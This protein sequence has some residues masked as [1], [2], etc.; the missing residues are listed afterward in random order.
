M[1][2]WRLWWVAAVFVVGIP[3]G[4][5]FSALGWLPEPA[6]RPKPMRIERA[7]AWWLERE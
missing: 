6:P 5:L 7:I 2:E 1:N 4:C 3:L